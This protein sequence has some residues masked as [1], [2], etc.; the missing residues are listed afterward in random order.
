[1]IGTSAVNMKHFIMLLFF[2]TTA[3]YFRSR[4]L[5]LASHW[6][7]FFKDTAKLCLSGFFSGSW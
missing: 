5:T 2:V 6:Q 4:G 1:M 7:F 3:V